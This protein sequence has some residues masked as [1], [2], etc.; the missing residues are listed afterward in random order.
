MTINRPILTL[1]RIKPEPVITAPSKKQMQR[2]AMGAVF[3]ALG[4]YEPWVKCYPLKIG[5][6]N[7]IL[8]LPELAGF[9]QKL[10]GLAIKI[11]VG[12][13]LY[14]ERLTCMTYRYDL[15]GERVG[16]IDGEIVS[17]QCQVS[18]EVSDT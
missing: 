3:A 10:I 15:A 4:K 17:Y 5:I 7:D 14:K 11:H 1:K 16:R 2:D 6:H 8:G 13:N 18:G 9:D 12:G